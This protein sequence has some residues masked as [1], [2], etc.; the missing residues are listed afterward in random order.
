MRGFGVLT[1]KKRTATPICPR[2]V[3]SD[4][5]IRTL[6]PAE[7]I[8]A[9][10]EELAAEITRDYAE[11]SLVIVCVLK[12]SFVFAADLVRSISSVSVFRATETA[13]SRAESFESRST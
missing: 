4:T 2:R 6:I 12:G 9:R 10:V 11:R 8:R 5:G 7:R 3:T 13:P 1:A